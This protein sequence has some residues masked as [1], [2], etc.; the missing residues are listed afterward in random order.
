M[1]RPLGRY[2]PPPPSSLV[3]RFLTA[4]FFELQTVPPPPPILVF[5]P[6]KNCFAASLGMLSYRRWQ[7]KIVAHICREK[8]VYFLILRHWA[9]STA[10]ARQGARSTAVAR[11]G[12]RST[13]VA[14]CFRKQT[15]PHVPIRWNQL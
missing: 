6:I 5:R 1:V 3:V 4:F 8:S 9:R 7:L 15:F 2:P 12:A 13:A 10:V 11:Q 14:S